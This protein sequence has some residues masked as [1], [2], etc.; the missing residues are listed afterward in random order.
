MSPCVTMRRALEDPELLGAVLAGDSW[1][2][3]RTIL[4]IAN[5]EPLS[6]EEFAIFNKRPP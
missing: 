3:W 2:N 4:I 6:E 1:R 5:G